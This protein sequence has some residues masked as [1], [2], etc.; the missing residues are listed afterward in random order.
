MR[1]IR[2]SGSEGGEAE[3]IGLSYPY[4]FSTPT[5]KLSIDSTRSDLI[6]IRGHLSIARRLIKIVDFAPEVK[7][8]TFPQ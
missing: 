3:S 1:E 2:L 7:H 8:G 5:Q 4:H 6:F